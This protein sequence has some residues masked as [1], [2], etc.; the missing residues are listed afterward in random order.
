MLNFIR[1]EPERVILP[2]PPATP[3]PFS[4][5]PPP[6]TPTSSTDIDLD[7]VA[8]GLPPPPDEMMASCDIPPPPDF[9]SSKNVS[10]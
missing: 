9:T 8:M 5:P 4:L 6:A 3:P 1:S 2:S 7:E 10:K